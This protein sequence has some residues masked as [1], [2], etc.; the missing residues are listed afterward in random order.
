LAI[1]SEE[2]DIPEYEER[3]NWHTLWMVD[4]LD[5]TKE[6][7]RRNGEFTV[8]IAKIKKGKPVLGIIYV[9]VTGHLYIG[10]VETG[11]TRRLIIKDHKAIGSGDFEA[12]LILRSSK[13]RVQ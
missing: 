4:P 7:V 6:F 3:K 8:N 12:A 11:Q 9:S 13:N 2:T 10:D 5:G 1:I